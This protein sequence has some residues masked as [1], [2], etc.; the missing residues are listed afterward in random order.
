MKRFFKNAV[1]III[2]AAMLCACSA[3]SSPAESPTDSESQENPLSKIVPE[4]E[5]YVISNYMSLKSGVPGTAFAPPPE[6]SSIPSGLAWVAENALITGDFSE[7]YS[8]TFPKEQ[9]ITPEQFA[10]LRIAEP[11]A[12]AV[13]NLADKIAADSSAVIALALA[14]LDADEKNEVF[15]YLDSKKAGEFGE[16]YILKENGQGS[17]EL[18]FDSGGIV[19]YNFNSRLLQYEGKW[20]LLAFDMDFDLKTIQGVHLYSFKD[21]RLFEDM[22]ISRA[23]D[24]LFILSKSGDKNMDALLTDTKKDAKALVKFALT[25]R[26]GALY[27]SGGDAAQKV[28]GSLYA[29][30]INNDGTDEYFETYLFLPDDKSQMY[31]SDSWY[32]DKETTKKIDVS[33]GDTNEN[34]VLHQMWTGTYEGKTLIYRLTR[35]VNSEAFYLNVFEI[36]GETASSLFGLGFI[37]SKKLEPTLKTLN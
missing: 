32:A 29:T 2:V 14:N 24:K 19:F 23:S 25:Q 27:K 10:A 8:F 15:V 37:Y 28:S 33:F 4:K 3:E 20:A 36:K 1:L 26:S 13:K 22:N 34:F 30:D 16:I 35:C 5:S 21:G 17:F 31:L 9:S 12:A 18:S 11:S 7:L 6:S